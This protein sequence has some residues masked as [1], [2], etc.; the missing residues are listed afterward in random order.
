MLNMFALFL[1]VAA[2]SDRVATQQLVGGCVPLEKAPATMTASSSVEFE[3]AKKALSA[4]TKGLEVAGY[5]DARTKAGLWIALELFRKDLPDQRYAVA[6]IVTGGPNRPRVVR[7]SSAIVDL[8]FRHHLNGFF[9]DPLIGALSVPLR[10]CRAWLGDPDHFY[11]ESLVL[12]V[13]GAKKKDLSLGLRTLMIES[14]RFGE[15]PSTVTL[16][17]AKVSSTHH[18]S[19]EITKSLGDAKARFAWKGGRYS[20]AAGAVD[21]LLPTP[22]DGP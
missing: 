11:R 9:E 10:V 3:A 16:R 2:A 12:L 15:D 21:P 5:K 20:L 13:P 19:R 18:G 7:S 22:S 6:A 4:Q 1:S 8:G 14:D 17:R